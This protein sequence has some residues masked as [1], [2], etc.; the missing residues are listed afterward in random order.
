MRTPGQLGYGL[1]PRESIVD[2]TRD[3]ADLRQQFAAIQAAQANAQQVQYV[4]QE[5]SG[6]N[7]PNDVTFHPYC[8]TPPIVVPAGCTRLTWNFNI[9]A[10]C[11]FTGAGFL[12]VGFGTGGSTLGSQV[13]SGPTQASGIPGDSPLSVSASWSGTATY[14]PGTTLYESVFVACSGAITASSGNASING[15]LTWSRS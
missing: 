5:V 10:G 12:D 13:Q 1:P 14:P 7:F 8:L 6:L 15:V 4:Y 3:L 9:T 2:L 11:T